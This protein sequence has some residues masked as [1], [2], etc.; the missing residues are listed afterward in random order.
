M[1]PCC[2]SSRSKKCTLSLLSGMECTSA[3]SNLRLNCQTFAQ[4]EPGGPPAPPR[5]FPHRRLFSKWGAPHLGE[6]LDSAWM[7][8]GALEVDALAQSRSP[9]SGGT[10]W[11]WAAPPTPG[12]VVPVALVPCGPRVSPDASCLSES[13]WDGE[14]PSGQTQGWSASWPPVPSKLPSSAHSAAVPGR[15]PPGPWAPP[16][17]LAL[18]TQ[19]C[20]ASRG[21]AP[22]DSVPGLVEE[23]GASL[24]RGQWAGT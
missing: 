3:P 6:V 4:L 12:S 1:N 19:P 11:C 18:P 22:R 10:R 21:R 8:P 20:L 16:C 7:A 17:F 24:W 2:S 23:R 15:L 9:V 14:G 13:W 5:C